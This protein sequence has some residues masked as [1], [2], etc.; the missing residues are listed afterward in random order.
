M[1][2]AAER[3]IS[4]RTAYRRLVAFFLIATHQKKKKTKKTTTKPKQQQQKRTRKK[5]KKEEKEKKSNE[6]SL[7]RKIDWKKK[8][9]PNKT[10]KQNC[11]LKKKY[12]VHELKFSFVPQALVQAFRAGHPRDEKGQ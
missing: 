4:A 9:P 7:K 2:T 8:Q 5:K 11:V 10:N 1:G 3:R 6:I 12:S